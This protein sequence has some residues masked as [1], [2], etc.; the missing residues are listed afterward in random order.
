MRRQVG[1]TLVELMVV[2]GIVLVLASLLLPV[3]FG[4]KEGQLARSTRAEIE[5][6]KSALEQY[7]NEFGDY[8]P[9]FLEEL[10]DDPHTGVINEGNRALVAC[11]ATKK[12]N[13]PYLRS[14]VLKDPDKVRLAHDGLP[15]TLI[16]HHDLTGWVFTDDPEHADVRCRELLD[17]WGTPYIYLHNRDYHSDAGQVYS[18]D[19]L[20]ASG[21][22]ANPCKVTARQ[23]D[24]GVYYG[25]YTFQIWSCG[26]NQINDYG[27]KDD[28][29]SWEAQ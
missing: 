15:N 10:G 29:T 13:G 18:M 14:Y 23:D 6:L 12:G 16:A 5:Y 26:P 4:A 21:S 28:I 24:D 1:F 17:A 2:V 11:L 27:G 19:G 20:N 3:F 8:P 9:S 25:A 22:P 7:K